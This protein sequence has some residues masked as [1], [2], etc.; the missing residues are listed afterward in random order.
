MPKKE[1]PK[2]MMDMMSCE[3]EG[4][5]AHKNCCGDGMCCM[6]GMGCGAGCGCGPASMESMHDKHSRHG[7]KMLLALCAS[8]F[9]LM[10][11]IW[12]GMQ[13]FGNPWYKNIR[14]EFTAAPYNRT[15]TV[16][17]M[18]KISAK[19]DLARVSLSVVSTGANVKAVTEDGNKK[20]TAV[21]D[22][23]KSLGVKAED[24][25]S[26]GYYLNPE[27][28]YNQPV[29]YDKVGTPVSKAPKIIGYSLTQ[30]VDVK[31][32]DLTKT[33][34]VIDKATAVGANQ[35]GSLSFDIDDASKVKN[36]ARE[37][38]FQKAREKAEMMAKAA[39]VKLGSV[40]TF[41]EGYNGGYPVP[42]ANFAV[43]SMDASG[44]ESV[45]PSIEPGSQELNISVSVTYEIE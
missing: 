8:L 14:A 7:G 6:D 36:Q 15:I 9:F 1:D 11:A 4:D 19:P 29:I 3:H 17:G 27:Y 37:I 18:G 33:E 21:I 23:M 16:D 2:M 31:V 30:S 32:R 42:Y 28:D 39:G 43:K 35:V 38:A 34:D 10:S 24:I 13:V 45:A 25:Q 20:M 41:S 5:K 12:V 44:G 26:T 40:V 22:Q